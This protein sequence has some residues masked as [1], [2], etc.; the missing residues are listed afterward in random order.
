MQSG[1]GTQFYYHLYSVKPIRIFLTVENPQVHYLLLAKIVDKETF[2][3]RNQQEDGANM[4]REYVDETSNKNT[5]GNLF[6]SI[7]KTVGVSI[8][9][10]D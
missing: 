7:V 6:Y 4:I 5:T 1:G 9:S 3:K 10:I 2:L 8:I